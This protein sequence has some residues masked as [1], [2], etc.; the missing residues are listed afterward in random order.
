MSSQTEDEVSGL[1]V[2]VGWCGSRA[3]RSNKLNAAGQFEIVQ[4]IGHNFPQ[5]SSR[6]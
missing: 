1:V 3:M 4:P 2:V 6:K 5:C